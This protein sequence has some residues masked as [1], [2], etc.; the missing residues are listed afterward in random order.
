MVQF[1]TYM[2]DA[3]RFLTSP[4]VQDELRAQ[5]KVAP[6]A[7]TLEIEEEKIN[8]LVFYGVEQIESDEEEEVT[9]KMILWKVKSGLGLWIGAVAQAESGLLHRCSLRRRNFFFSR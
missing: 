6:L 8:S 1:R 4:D 9:Y 2:T 5:G 3:N 7:E